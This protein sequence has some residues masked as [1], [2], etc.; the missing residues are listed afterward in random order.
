MIIVTNYL[1][2]LV[3]SVSLFCVCASASAEAMWRYTV[4]PGDSL[5][6]LANQHLINADDWRILQRLNHINDPYRLAIGSV[7]R[8]PLTMV[9]QRAA[10]AQVTFVSGQAYWQQ[11]ANHWLPLEI[12]K[13]LGPGAVI[14]TKEKSKVVIQ[15]ADGSTT[16]VDS[17]SRLS[18]DGLTLYSGGAMVD[19][20]LR[21]QKGQIETNANPQHVKGNQLQVITPSAIAAVR[22]THF[23]VTANE[24]ETIQETLDGRVAL[25]AAKQAV[26]VD[27][28]YGSK[29]EKG[30]QPIPPVTLLPAV[31]TTHL[32][33]QYQALPITFDLPQ[34]EGVAGWV[35][36]IATDS[37]FNQLVSEAEFNR[38]QLVFAD[39]PD[40]QLYLKLCAKDNEG[41]VGYE[42]V[43][44]FNVNAR[45]F[46][47]EIVSPAVDAI[48]REVQPTLQW[49]PV[50]DAQQYLV[51]VSSDLA[52]NQLLASKQLNGLSLELDKPLMPG[53]Y[54]W[55][56]I[57]LASTD[58]GGLDKGPAMQVNT[59]SYKAKPDIPDISQ[60]SVNVVRNRVFVRTLPPLN[61]LTYRVSLTNPFN[62]QD[63]VWQDAGL[64]GQFDFLLREY[65]EQI[66]YI[67]HVDSDGVESAPAIYAFDAQPE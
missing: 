3:L 55:R 24:Q 59:F 41:I 37:D 40:G 63:D 35:A 48:V 61:G 15:F 34:M 6:A 17:N 45:P 2:I 10:S 53:Q 51:E 19:T 25:N 5:I 29:A 18:L 23:R 62:H 16:N 47:P 12:G 65:G 54:Y 11:S 7:L 38:N 67:R 52:F 49:R 1:Q 30:K 57:S 4:R 27:K 9:K 66:L 21:L 32:H 13:Q 46:Q 33:T 43:H 39:V 26:T 22:G 50:K 64:T 60:I 36:K 20:K 28:G 8:I 58:D 42:A 56:V 31:D 44:T 14:A